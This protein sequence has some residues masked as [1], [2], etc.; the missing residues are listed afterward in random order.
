VSP[1]Q[2]IGQRHKLQSSSKTLLK[3]KERRSKKS[4]GKRKSSGLL[5]GGTEALISLFKDKFISWK[6]GKIWA[7]LT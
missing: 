2:R 5:P 4:H 6:V 3:E 7:V 1:E